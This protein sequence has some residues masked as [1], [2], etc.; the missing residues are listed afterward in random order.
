MCMGTMITYYVVNMRGDYRNEKQ[1]LII[2]MRYKTQK[3][4]RI[5]DENIDIY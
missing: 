3:R 4:D 1:D 5:Q 2:R